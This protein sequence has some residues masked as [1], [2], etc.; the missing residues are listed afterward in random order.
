MIAPID[1]AAV[2]HVNS[3]ILINQQNELNR[4]CD[5]FQF[6]FSTTSILIS[7]QLLV[8]L[9][10]LSKIALW[11]SGITLTFIGKYILY[12][13]KWFAIYDELPGFNFISF[14]TLK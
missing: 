14:R 6:F 13:K 11:F 10:A 1:I 4:T 2:R 5:L 9:Y 8:V 12:R 3:N 7:L